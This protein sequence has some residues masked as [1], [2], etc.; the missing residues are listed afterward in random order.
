MSY[1]RL[2]TIG[3]DAEPLTVA[4]KLIVLAVAP[5]SRFSVVLE[6]DRETLGGPD[7]TPEPLPPFPPPFPP[8]PPQD[9]QSS[10]ATRKSRY[11]TQFPRPT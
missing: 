3:V 11:R 4:V 5:S 2:G 1:W 7:V 8:P 10:I 9:E 6:E